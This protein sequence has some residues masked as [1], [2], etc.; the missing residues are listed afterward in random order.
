MCILLFAATVHA[1]A[2]A[3]AAGTV[4]DRVAREWERQHGE[5]AAII[6]QRGTLY[7]KMRGD[8]VGCDDRE[9]AYDLAAYHQPTD[10]DPLT[11]VLRRTGALLDHLERTAAGAVADRGFRDR[12]DALRGQA[13]ADEAGRKSLYFQACALRRQIIFSNPLLAIDRIVFGTSADMVNCVYFVREGGRSRWIVHRPFADQPRVEDIFADNTVT[14]GRFAGRKIT[15]G[16]LRGLDV[17]Y[18]G[19]KIAF[20]W[21]LNRVDVGAFVPDRSWHVFQANADG[22]QC[23]QLTD[24]RFHD[25]DPCYLPSGRIAFT[26]YRRDPDIRR[27]HIR[28]TSTAPE[29]FTLHSCAADGNDVVTLSYHDLPEYSPAVATTAPTGPPRT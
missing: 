6:A 25:I 18:D 19:R 9:H 23:V 14:A 2:Q 7:R 13:P 22:S 24:G 26:S 27:L 29:V 28:C 1:L 3:P 17:S 10:K 16:W 12:L 15:D 8:K 11:V 4:R 21:S 5:M 20:C